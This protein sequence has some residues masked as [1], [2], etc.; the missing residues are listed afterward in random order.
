MLIGSANAGYVIFI[1]FGANLRHIWLSFV[2]MPGQIFISRA[3]HQIHHSLERKH[4]NK[5]YGEAFAIWDRMFGSLYVPKSH[6]NVQH[7]LS[8]ENGARIAQ[9]Y[10]TLCAA[11]MVPFVDCWHTLW[12]GTSRDPALKRNRVQQETAQ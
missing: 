6:E 2:P 7:G 8:D 11:L 12:K 4:Y 9:P 1:I 3:Q 5:N 10:A